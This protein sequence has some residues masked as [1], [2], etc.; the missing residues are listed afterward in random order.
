MYAIEYV[1]PFCHYTHKN[2]KWK[3]AP[4]LPQS[5]QITLDKLTSV[6]YIKISNFTHGSEMTVSI[7]QE[8]TGPLVE[9]YQDK[10]I[11]KGKSL[12]K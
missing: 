3:E 2:L 7:S 6:K 5:F 9:V 4:F 8:E 11:C 10:F 12:K 1:E